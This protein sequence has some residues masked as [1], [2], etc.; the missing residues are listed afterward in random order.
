MS[1]RRKEMSLAAAIVAT[2]A[3]G[4]VWGTLSAGVTRSDE[5]VEAGLFTERSLFCPGVPDGVLARPS[6]SVGA[7]SPEEVRVE[8]EPRDDVPRDVLG[9]AGLFAEEEGTSPSNVVGYGGAVGAG[10]SQNFSSPVAGES[11][12]AC[13]QR[14][15]RNWYLPLG[16]SARG[17]NE[18]IY[19][20]NPFPDEAVVRV[21]FY[22][23]N[24]PISKARL[25][26]VAVPAGETT[27]VKVNQFIL[28]QE[29][30]AAEV[31]TLRGRVVAWKTLFSKTDVTSGAANSL[32]ATGA[33]P[34]WYFP[35]GAVGPDIEERISLLNPSD[36]EAI[37]SVSL[38]ADEDVQQPPELL[39][40][41]LPRQ[42]ARDISLARFIPDDVAGPVSAIAQSINEVGI[43]AER[44]VWYGEGAFSGVTTELGAP[45]PAPA[46][47]LPPAVADPERDSV[48]VLNA[49]ENP[50][51]VDLEFQGPDG[52]VTADGVG[53]VNLEP[54][55]RARIPLEG[56][57]DGGRTL[58]ILR[59]DG[60]VV[61][62][63]LGYSSDSNDVAAVM[64]IPIHAEPF[65]GENKQR[66]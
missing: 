39:E 17:Y 30:L 8:L 49:S 34:F 45:A 65:S 48:V 15:A 33:A 26:D 62:E 50:V 22:D 29:T 11:A 27:T 59:A 19:L 51:K 55:G 7:L 25:A 12:A 61:A 35:S 57:S 18:L 43:V 31:S 13:S 46:W 4:L 6:I 37:V 9:D 3:L 53:S 58:A 41:T 10:I 24:G 64:G 44:G 56:L 28:Q 54:G 63:R 5:A 1:E 36:E 2:I 47:W 23:E 14:A 32:G 38:I 21:T 60:L 66:D 40:M 42:S 20:Y 52:P 16:S